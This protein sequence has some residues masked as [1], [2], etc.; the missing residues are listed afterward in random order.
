MSDVRGENHMPPSTDQ[1]RVRLLLLMTPEPLMGSMD[2]ASM[3]PAEIPHASLPVRLHANYPILARIASIGTG[4]PPLKHGVHTRM[5]FEPADGGLRP[6]RSDDTGMPWLWDLARRGGC[7]TSTIDWPLINDDDSPD[8]V[9]ML[10]MQD[11]HGNVVSPPNMVEALESHLQS[12]LLTLAMN[13]HLQSK[14]PSQRITPEAAAQAVGAMVERLSPRTEHEHLVVYITTKTFD[15]LLVFGPRADSIRKKFVSQSDLPA[16]ILDML[17]VEKTADIPGWSVFDVMDDEETMVGWPSLDST[18]S[19]EDPIDL[20]IEAVQNGRQDAA[21]YVVNWLT[22]SWICNARYRGITSTEIRYAQL[23][24]DL[25]GEAQDL[26]RLAVSADLANDPITFDSARTRLHSEY[27]DSIQARLADT[28]P[29]ARPDPDQL[30][31]AVDA[32]PPADMLPLQLRTWC[33]AA[34]RAGLKEQAMEPLGTLVNRGEGMPA[35]RLQL[36]EL[37]MNDKKPWKALQAL[38]LIGTNPA[39]LPKLAAV[40]A[41]IL[42]AC[43]LPEPAR[44]LLEAALAATPM[45][46]EA[47]AILDSIEPRSDD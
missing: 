42:L 4:F 27:P 23:L 36:A 9:K 40:R 28:L 6:R 24:C 12:D 14:D 32:N 16:S 46:S 11:E 22:S 3:V 44:Q 5:R 10:G 37:Y 47:K 30:R 8:C 38:G 13:L 17:Q 31:T 45:D 21:T 34:I 1:P 41:R 33:H 18:P 43:D 26:F 7:T 25:R 15:H 29:A 20:A 39:A 35:D 2:I 19:N